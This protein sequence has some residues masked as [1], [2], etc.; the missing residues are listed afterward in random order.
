MEEDFYMDEDTSAQKIAEN[1]MKKIESDFSNVQL[2][3]YFWLSKDKFFFFSI[4][5]LF[6]KK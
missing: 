1:E 6:P 3:F 4:L 2:I 5:K